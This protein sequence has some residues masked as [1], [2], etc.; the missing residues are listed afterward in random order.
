MN[1]I[2]STVT[3]IFLTSFI[4][5]SLGRVIQNRFSV[6]TE[7]FV[8][9]YPLGFIAY[10]SI[11]QILYA[12]FI[13][14]GVSPSALAIIEIVKNIAIILIVLVNYDDWLKVSIFTSKDAMA[15]FSFFTTMFIGTYL[16]MQFS[17]IGMD[18]ST[19]SSGLLYQLN[20]EIINSSTESIMLINTGTSLGYSD[21]S[22]STNS[23]Y[24]WMSLKMVS[25]NSDLYM[26]NA[27]LIT[28]MF[29]ALSFTTSIYLSERYFKGYNKYFASGILFFSMIMFSMISAPG[30][31]SYFIL[32]LIA[33][34][35]ALFT[36]YIGVDG[37]SKNS[38]VLSTIAMFAVTAFATIGILFIFIWMIGIIF[39]QMFND[40]RFTLFSLVSINLI[41]F[42]LF[43]AISYMSTD[44]YV[45]IIYMLIVIG[46]SL[47]SWVYY[48]RFES[49][50]LK[51]E[52]FFS[53]NN[54][55]LLVMFA[56]IT[57][58]IGTI[59]IITNFDF[60]MESILIPFFYS[61]YSIDYQATDVIA[62]IFDDLILFILMVVGLYY[63]NIRKKESENR[64]IA[65][66]S[67]ILVMIF[68]NPLSISFFS[69]LFFNSIVYVKFFTYF[70][71]V[72]IG[73]IFISK[74]DKFS[75]KWFNSENIFAFMSSIVWTVAIVFVGLFNVNFNIDTKTMTYVGM[76]QTTEY[77]DTYIPSGSYVVGDLYMYHGTNY[78]HE[79]EYEGFI[80]ENNFITEITGIINNIDSVTTFINSY[81][82]NVSGTSDIYL[83]KSSE[84]MNFDYSSTYLNECDSHGTDLKVFKIN[85]T[86]T[87]SACTL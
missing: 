52:K 24:Y 75:F 10:W 74:I 51:I 56:V 8:I 45:W 47:A 33:I 70:F 42:S 30:L 29:Y 61:G 69:L 81:S 73:L 76:N 44:F 46:F 84:L 57:M 60:Y 9:S 12:P 79:T 71:I 14:F 64:S 80:E 3:M 66:F 68:I 21:Y 15:K 43:N 25:L 32:P 87:T 63:Y 58:G 28:F 55:L 22:F 16:I 85:S 20:D 34:A 2:G 72:L 40:D 37:K 54:S 6:S 86:M 78:I 62:S 39:V 41:L 23:Y 49:T 27:W 17:G 26:L 53:E 4:F 65:Y 35:W 13:A 77:I 67:L 5:Y 59:L 48:K 18:A 31:G 83:V 1:A 38:L 19:T 11:T 82:S 36:N 7:S 50:H